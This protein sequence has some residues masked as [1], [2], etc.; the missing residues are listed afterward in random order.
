MAFVRTRAVQG[1]E[2]LSCT[3]AMSMLL[4]RNEGIPCS[5]K[6]GSRLNNNTLQRDRLWPQEI[7]DRQLPPLA[8]IN[9]LSPK[10][11]NRKR[12][13]PSFEK[14]PNDASCL[15]N[16]CDVLHHI[17]LFRLACSA[18][19]RVSATTTQQKHQINKYTK[20]I[21]TFFANDNQVLHALRPF[22]STLICTIAAIC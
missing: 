7:F 22:L 21:T 10:E 14:R 11:M 16:P 19:R 18:L 15:W 5:G 8:A 12:H 9:S 3:T 17:T 2:T 4:L 6:C 13:K 20:G 1:W